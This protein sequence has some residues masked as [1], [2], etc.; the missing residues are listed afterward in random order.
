MQNDKNETNSLMAKY[1]IEEALNNAINSPFLETSLDGATGVIMNI[2]AASNMMTL[3]DVI[4]AG[5]MLGE[6][7]SPEA[8]V[9][10]GAITDDSLGESVKITIIVTGFCDERKPE[11]IEKIVN[12]KVNPNPFPMPSNIEFKIL[13]LEA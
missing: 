3:S 8:N 13:F 12:D 9:I 7:A 1:A 2:T 6:V 5:D 11:V 10:F 4:E